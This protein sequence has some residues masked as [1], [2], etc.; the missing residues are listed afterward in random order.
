ME[1]RQ[2]KIGRG[3]DND[4]V[5]P[6]YNT[7]VSNSHASITRNEDGSSYIFEDNSS[8]GTLINGRKINRQSVAVS[9]GDEIMLAGQYHL[10]WNDIENAFPNKMPPEETFNPHQGMMWD[11]R[12]TLVRRLGNGA[13]A[14]VWEALDTKAG[15]IKVALKI[16][17]AFGN[18]GTQGMQ[19]FMDEFK[20]VHGLIQTNLLIPS[21]YDLYGNVPYLVT[22]FCEN[23][24]AQKYVG[25][26]DEAEIARFMK[27][28]ALGLDY[29]HKHG[30]VHQDFKPDNIL[31]DEDG[32][33][34]LT[35]FGISNQSA[36]KNTNGTQSYMGPERFGNTSEAMPQ[37]DIW[38]FGASV[39]ELIT[40]DVPFGDNGGMVQA[41][42]EKIPALPATFKSAKIKSLLTRCLDENPNARPTAEEI[43]FE[44]ED[45][46]N[47]KKMWLAAAAIAAIIALV[48][49]VAGNYMRLRTVYYKDYAEYWGVPKGIHKISESEM[50]H[51]STT[52]R[53][54]IKK[55][56]VLRMSL[57]NSKGKIVPHTDSELAGSRC[58]DIKYEYS[59]DGKLDYIVVYDEFGQVQYKLDYGEFKNNRTIATYMLDDENESPMFLKQNTASTAMDRSQSIIGDDF[60]N[61]MKLKLEFDDKGRLTKKMY[62][63]NTSQPTHDQN[64]IFGF[65][66]QYEKDGGKDRITEVHFLGR[67]GNIT[68]YKTGLAIKQ[69]EYDDDDNL[70]IY[71]YLD[72][73]RNAAQ[74]D[75][76]VTVEEHYFDQYG[77]RY[78]EAY[79]TLDGK[80]A[81]NIS[82][83]H[84][85]VEELDEYGQDTLL[86]YYD[87]EG[88]TSVHKFGFA[89]CKKKYDDN[90]FVKEYAFFDEKDNPA[91]R[92][93]GNGSSYHKEVNVFTSNGRTLE[94]AYLGL[95]GSYIENKDGIAKYKHEYDSLGN[96]VL[97]QFFDAKGLPA[98][99]EGSI[100]QI[101][102]EY[103]S[104]N[105]LIS[106]QYLDAD[107]KLTPDADGVKYIKF[108]RDGFGRL[109][110]YS[111]LDS[112]GFPT[113]ETNKDYAYYTVEYDIASG[114]INKYTYFDAKDKHT[115]KGNAIVK[116]TFDTLTNFNNRVTYCNF[117]GSITEDHH[118][119][120]D[121][122]GN[123]IQEY[124]LDNDQKLIGVVENYEYDDKNRKTK[125]YATDFTG[126]K[127]NFRRKA[128]AEI[129]YEEYN[130]FNNCVLRS[131]WDQN[132]DPATD[133]D[134]AHKYEFKFDIQGN[135]TYQK[136]LGADGKPADIPE[137]EYEAIYDIRGNMT[138]LRCYDGYG[139]PKTGDDGMYE[140]RYEYNNKNQE[141][142]CRYLGTDGQP[143]VASGY[144]WHMRKYTYDDK[145]KIASE[146]YYDASDNPMEP[147]S[148]GYFLVQYTYDDKGNKTTERLFNTKKQLEWLL[149]YNQNGYVTERL[150]YEDG[151]EQYEYKYVRIFDS[152]GTPT[153]ENV[154]DHNGQ[155]IAYRKYDSQNGWGKW[156]RI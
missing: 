120:Y 140:T 88:N 105:N 96:C 118:Y 112:D 7:H 127:I 101:K 85:C 36:V 124:E 128:Y 64:N 42:G 8:N 48:S 155:Y 4:I 50:Q 153:K 29:L 35:D 74:D 81:N 68:P 37:S 53:L 132:G 45:S 28:T 93:D 78:A 3:S 31:I 56:K 123:I 103:D 62:L 49:I 99:Y 111:Y 67:N 11:S 110:K 9:P 34:V 38:S 16:Y 130:E 32:N 97:T 2:I 134:G 25:H 148:K 119:K 15:N 40:G 18:I 19:I 20:T 79:F 26:M 70:S 23:G 138:A 52:Y 76:R 150:Q 51:R 10:L 104:K 107:G 149:S 106:V 6:E 84:K 146:E 133:N 47:R 72:P 30:I 102:K 66:Y 63:N 98:K 33:Y 90:G 12:Y 126:S 147:E 87:I 89:K 43:V 73:D 95:D 151:S 116:Y 108:T 91:M 86:Y 135:I 129:R 136:S 109:T 71:R 94:C 152:E 92:N 24:S 75:N 131:Y 114:N 121:S 22:K 61:I 57:V 54:E 125:Y 141:T 83:I 113:D 55:G 145:G 139:N 122:N 60:S 14:Q 69:F 117:K 143:V 144:G 5:V 1:K 156:I 80:P 21:G 65:E 59:G 27:D 137:P 115:K 17:S 39:F 142:T 82:N 44:L 58:A 77:N 46:G 13:T 154:Y 41:A 100:S